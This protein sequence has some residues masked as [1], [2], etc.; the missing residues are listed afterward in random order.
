MTCLGSVAEQR[1]VCYRSRTRRASRACAEKDLVQSPW[2]EPREAQIPN[3]R[4][5]ACLFLLSPGLATPG[6]LPSGL[7]ESL[8]SP[9]SITPCP[10]ATWSLPP[11]LFPSP[12][13]S[14]G[15]A[16]IPELT[17]LNGECPLKSLTLHKCSNYVWNS[18]FESLFSDKKNA[19]IGLGRS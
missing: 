3:S 2:L 14:P 19:F 13:C 9:P 15:S 7:H 18:S 10:V 1:V 17:H 5:S 12:S 11:N 16:D 4:G 6:R 8:P